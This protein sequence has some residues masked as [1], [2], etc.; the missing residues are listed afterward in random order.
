MTLRKRR[1]LL[2]ISVVVFIIV[3]PIINLY[4]LGFRINSKFKL[5]KTGGIYIYSP[6]NG[7]KIFV[8]NKF[9]KETGFIQSGYFVQN[10]EPGK[11]SVLV[12]KEGFWPWQKN[13]EVKEELVSETRAF[14][15]PKEPEGK[16]IIR[17]LFSNL[18]A[19]PNQK[20]LLLIENNS[21][22]GKNLKINFYAPEKNSFLNPSSLTSLKIL[23][24]GKIVKSKWTENGVIILTEK[25]LIN[26]SLNLDSLIYEAK[27]MD[28]KSADEKTLFAEPEEF[29]NFKSSGNKNFDFNLA[30]LSQRKKE[31]IYWD[32]NKNTIFFD[33]ANDEK[34]LPYFIFG[35]NNIKLPIKIFTFKYP[36]TNIEFLSGRK[37]III[38][39]VRNGIYAMELDGR[40]GRM[41]QPIYKG[42]EPNFATL[43]GEKKIY[44]LDEG[45]LSEIKI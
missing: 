7:S 37:D 40:G 13:I 25:S 34:Q 3:A 28:R 26:V 30:R 19:S 21:K 45:N 43:K 11:Y 12:A 44:I 4:I 29:V 35:E 10:L 31:L 5:T 18:F 27:L 41:I 20:V 17:G 42:K 9:E 14:L 38:V 2:L 39:A 15:I 36:I 22:N 32:Y 16:T 24:F 1:I 33:F 23:S 6:E 8:N